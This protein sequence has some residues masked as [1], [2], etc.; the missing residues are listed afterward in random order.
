MVLGNRGRSVSEVIF[1]P[2]AKLLHRLHITPNAVTYT[3]AV[4]VAAISFGLIARGHLGLGGVLVGVVLFADSVDGILA[5]LSGQE[6]QYGA[7]LDSTM[8]RVTDGMVFAAL[9]WWAIMGLPDNAIRTVSII[10]GIACMTLV[11][12]V[13]YARAKAE[14]FGVAAKVGI[15]ER[16]D[17]L[18]IA[19]V[20]A[21]LTDWGL[22]K[23][24]YAAG[25]T[26]VAFASAVTVLQRVV[27]TAKELKQAGGT[28]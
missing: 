23:W 5:R 8:D 3:S 16:T 25:L 1:T 26:W 9:L 11:G 21:G 22:P 18:I 24:F 13:P 27:Y 12:V 14:N 4:F 2:F 6:S 7:F 28:A 19:L 10:S 17:R 15:A 20:G